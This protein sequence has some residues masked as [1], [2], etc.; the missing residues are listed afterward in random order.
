M[1]NSASPAPNLPPWP[2]DTP[3]VK[4]I[5]TCS[6]ALLSRLAYGRPVYLLVDAFSGSPDGFD[7]VD[8][9]RHPINT[10]YLKVLPERAPYLLELEDRH[11]PL[12]D[13]SLISAVQEHLNACAD[14]GGPCRIGGW[15]QT[16]GSD[17]A[18]LAIQLSALFRA[19]GAPNGGRYLRLADRR[20]LALLQQASRLQDVLPLPSIDWSLGLQGIAVWTYMD[21][22]FDLQSLQG[23]AGESR[24][25]P[26]KLEAS[27]WTLLL[28]AEAI[29]RT[30]MAWQRVCH[31]L[32]GDAAARALYKVRCASQLGLVGPE[33]QSAHAAE[34]LQHPAFEAW[35]GL[36]H[37]L[38]ETILHEWPLADVL[39]QQRANWMSSTSKNP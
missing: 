23:A 5:E 8:R 26:L 14:G 27:H 13:Q 19:R 30:L 1:S 16:H 28:Q 38:A 9:P 31:P 6:A 22:D 33:N 15:L 17:G 39:A 11:D 34:A 25:R 35:T 18:A 21:M 29:N 37:C 10:K 32:P 7:A 12:L 4:L 3:P 24:P 36:S 20:V 2:W